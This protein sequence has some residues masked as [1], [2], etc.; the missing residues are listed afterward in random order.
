[1]ITISINIIKVSLSIV[2]INVFDAILDLLIR[3]L[4]VILSDDNVLS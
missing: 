3:L 2:R 4:H 1:M